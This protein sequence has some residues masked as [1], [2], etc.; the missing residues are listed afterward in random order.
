M[1]VRVYWD[2]N[3]AISGFYFVEKLRSFV[4]S[5][6]NFCI[7]FEQAASFEIAAF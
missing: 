4:H 5:E 1:H 7:S 3:T 2:Q 6:Q